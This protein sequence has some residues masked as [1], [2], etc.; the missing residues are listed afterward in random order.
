VNLDPEAISTKTRSRQIQDVSNPKP[1][2]PHDLN[3][4]T[5]CCDQNKQER[6]KSPSSVQKNRKLCYKCALSPRQDPCQPIKNY[7]YT[8]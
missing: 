3:I 8:N 6:A 5:V 1:S 7:R 4:H 2:H